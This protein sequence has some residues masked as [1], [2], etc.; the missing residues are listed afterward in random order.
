M[1]PVK[2]MRRKDRKFVKYG[3][4]PHS[5]S[6]LLIQYMIRAYTV[7]NLLIDIT[8]TPQQF[9]FFRKLTLI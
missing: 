8:F 7:F 9:F 1:L 2:E 6:T 4:S 3:I 5:Y